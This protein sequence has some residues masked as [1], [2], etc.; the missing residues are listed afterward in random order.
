MTA[1][2]KREFQE[3]SLLREEY[4]GVNVIVSGGRYTCVP[5][6]LFDGDGADT[7][8][9]YSQQRID[10]EVV[11][12][13]MLKNSNAAVLFG[14][15]R[16]TY[17]FV[18]EHFVNV[19]FYSQIA[20]L[21]EYLSVKSRQGGLQHRMY[22]ALRGEGIDLLCYAQ[23]NLLLVNSFDTSRKADRIYYILATW[24]QLEFNQEIDELYLSGDRETRESMAKELRRYISHVQ[25]TTP[26]KNIDIQELNIDYANY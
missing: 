1:N 17:N 12:V 25:A 23:G 11:L 13:N 3:L 22:V 5:Q 24:K 19:R 7:L 16:S 15:D 4:R 26:E 20:L 2:L 8:Y 6:E 14:V 10:N 21:N 18:N 9:H